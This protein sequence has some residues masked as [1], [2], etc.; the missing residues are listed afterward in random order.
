M[1]WLEQVTVLW[2]QSLLIFRL[3]IT[4]IDPTKTYSFFLEPV[5]ISYQSYVANKLKKRGS[6][7]SFASHEKGAFISA[8]TGLCQ[9]GSLSLIIVDLS[10]TTLM[11]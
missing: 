7:H 3:N 10:H 6:F 4:H 2:S 8:S 5:H 11:R 9:P 1:G